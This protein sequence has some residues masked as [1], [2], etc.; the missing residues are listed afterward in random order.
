MEIQK[1]KDSYIFSYDEDLYLMFLIPPTKL[2]PLLK[3]LGFI[4]IGKV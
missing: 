1:V 4:K 3:E 2:I